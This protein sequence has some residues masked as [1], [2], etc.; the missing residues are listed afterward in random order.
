[1]AQTGADYGI[2][3]GEEAPP[4]KLSLASAFRWLVEA[5]AAQINAEQMSRIEILKTM[6]AELIGT[7]VAET[8][9]VPVLIIDPDLPSAL[10]TPSGRLAKFI[11]DI[12]AGD[13][14]TRL[15]SPRVASFARTALMRL[16]QAGRAAFAANVPTA[17][18]GPD[19]Q[20][21]LAWRSGVHYLELEISEKGPWEFFYNDEATGEMFVCELSE[22]AAVPV[23]IRERLRHFVEAP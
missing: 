13:E 1:M 18:P 21:M 14:R 15:I 20:L 19:G 5:R 6:L 17:T 11:R 7:S 10:P 2:R 12:S 16:N 9:G 4:A 3:G 8:E 23:T 22:D